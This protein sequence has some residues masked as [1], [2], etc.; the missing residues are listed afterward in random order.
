MS[1]YK[2]EADEKNAKL[3]TLATRCF[4]NTADNF[5]EIIP[6]AQKYIY[7]PD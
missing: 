7:R 6:E 5:P 3:N 1:Q 4:L 2:D